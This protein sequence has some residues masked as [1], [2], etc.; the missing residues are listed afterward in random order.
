MKTVIKLLL[1]LLITVLCFARCAKLS[2]DMWTE[3]IPRPQIEIDTIEVHP[4]DTVTLNNHNS[5]T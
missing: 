5:N 3:R 4:W 2:E 1:A